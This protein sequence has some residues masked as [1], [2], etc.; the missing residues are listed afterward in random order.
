MIFAAATENDT[1]ANRGE[2]SINSGINGLAQTT[3]R[4]SPP[5]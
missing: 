2:K 4:E 3:T 5:A 1:M